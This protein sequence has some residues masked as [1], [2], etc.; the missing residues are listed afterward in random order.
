MLLTGSEVDF[1]AARVLVSQS[2][3]V[4]GNGCLENLRVRLICV[5][6]CAGW[7]DAHYICSSKWAQGR[8]AAANIQ[9]CECRTQRQGAN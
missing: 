7:M 4:C 9:W 5:P 1:I 3:F 6:G 2:S 8:S